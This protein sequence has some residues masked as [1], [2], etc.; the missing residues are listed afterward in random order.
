MP[1]FAAASSYCFSCLNRRSFHGPSGPARRNVAPASASSAI[2]FFPLGALPAGG[3]AMVKQITK[4]FLPSISRTESELIMTW[5]ARAEGTLRRSIPA[6]TDRA[7]QQSK[8]GNS[9]L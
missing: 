9:Q 8:Y 1:Y 5:F 3:G 4:V 2:A 7:P 6:Q